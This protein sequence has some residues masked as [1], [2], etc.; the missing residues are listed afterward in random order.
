MLKILVPVDGSV[1]AE[2]AVAHAISLCRSAGQGQIEL[3][4]VQISI[5]SGHVR[6]F[7]SDN[8]V[9][10]YHRSEG[11][12]ALAGARRLLDEAGLPYAHHVVVGHVADT[13]VRFA[14]ERQVDQIVMGSHGHGVMLDLLLGSVAR[15]VVKA[16]QLP[17]TL[18]K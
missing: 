15:D 18:V 12:N 16:A 2:R 6:L 13:I 1:Q 5:D 4:N 9:T 10:A 11:E 14:Q 3:L 8:D 7:V 17:V